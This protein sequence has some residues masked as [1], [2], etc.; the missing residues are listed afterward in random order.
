MALKKRWKRDG[1]DELSGYKGVM[2]MGSDEDWRKRR[3][4]R[5]DR[6]DER[7]DYKCLSKDLSSQ[8]TL[9][10]PGISETRCS[11]DLKGC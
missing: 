6:S 10:Q 3:G 4:K 2:R 11:N 9:V 8:F 7:V 5:V 1:N